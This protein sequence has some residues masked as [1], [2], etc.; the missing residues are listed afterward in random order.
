MVGS[1]R[2]SSTDRCR[3]VAV[4][5]AEAD[6]LAGVTASRAAPSYTRVGDSY[7]AGTTNT[8]WTRTQHRTNSHLWTFLDS[9]HQ[10]PVPVPRSATC[11]RW[12][13]RSRRHRQTSPQSGRLGSPARWSTNHRRRRQHTGSPAPSAVW[14]AGLRGR[15]RWTRPRWRWRS[16]TPRADSGRHSGWSPL[17]SRTNP[18]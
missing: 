15:R 11:G 8:F 17:G 2:C 13:D 16:E 1:A 10:N 7:P 18:S 5:P 12:W 9:C 6:D 3:V 4:W 14:P